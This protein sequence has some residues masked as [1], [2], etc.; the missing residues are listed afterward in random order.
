MAAQFYQ[1]HE[2]VTLPHAATHCNTL[3]H[4]A[5]HCNTQIDTLQHTAT[6]CN[7]LQHTA[8]ECNTDLLPDPSKNSMAE[9]FHE[10]V[11]L[12]LTA[13]H[14]NTLQHTAT[15]CNTLQHTATHCNTDLL[16]DP[17]KVSMAELFHQIHEAV[18]DKLSDDTWCDA[19]DSAYEYLSGTQCVV[20]CCSVLQRVAACCSV[21]RCVIATTHGVTLMTRPMSICQVHS[22]L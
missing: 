7:T 22:V 12:P 17:S 1:V 9:L 14:C 18:N 4:T 20:V 6:H 19:H 13:T 11:T 16:P 3:Q 21:L 10:A 2:A 15:H 5:T 8:T